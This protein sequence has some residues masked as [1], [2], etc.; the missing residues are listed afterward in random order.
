MFSGGDVIKDEHGHRCERAAVAAGV[1]IAPQ[2]LIPEAFRDGQ[3]RPPFP[4][5][6]PIP[7]LPDERRPGK[8]MFPVMSLAHALAHETSDVVSHVYCAR[9][10]PCPQ[11]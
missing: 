6:V 5:L 8:S 1:V 9:V 2:H 4:S 3:P 11:T 10:I 7:A